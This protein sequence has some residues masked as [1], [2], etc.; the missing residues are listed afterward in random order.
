MD[1]F[2]LLKKIRNNDIPPIIFLYGEE[3]Y[4]IQKIKDEIIKQVIK[5]DVENLSIYDLEETPIEEVVVDVETYPFFGDKKLIIAE[6]PTFVLSRSPKLSFEHQ[7]KHL[8]QYIASPVDYSIL[9]IIAPYEKI[10]QRKKIT[11]S[12]VKETLS[13]KFDHIK[14]R[15][16]TKWIGQFA[17]MYNLSIDKEALTYIEANMSVDLQSL[18]N[19]MQKL[20]LYVGEGGV[21]TK[22][23]AEKLLSSSIDSSAFSLVDAVIT[24]NVEQAF[25]VFKELMMMNE[26]AIGLLALLS[27]QFRTILQVKLLKGKGYNDYQIQRQIGAHP[28]T[29]KLAAERG[30]KFHTERLMNIINLLAETDANIKTGK[31]DETIG[32][33]LLLYELTGK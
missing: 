16:L 22:E 6:N 19:E 13:I 9:I 23:I 30:R 20:S 24:K 12:L 25:T 31:V 4:F 7:I 5:D 27:Q 17:K 18:E 21:V 10:D 8:E 1:Y 32:L 11:K 3:S 26:S 29:I 14:E 2:T 33:E 28:Y 15:D